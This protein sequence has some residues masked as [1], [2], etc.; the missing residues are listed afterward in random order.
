LLVPT[1]LLLVLDLGVLALLRF[2]LFSSCAMAMRSA[3]TF[4][5]DS[6]AAAVRGSSF[7]SGF[8]FPTEKYG[9][10]EEDGESSQFKYG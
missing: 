1:H 8:V 6:V 3:L 4:T 9:F 2:F 10:E 5:F 7:L